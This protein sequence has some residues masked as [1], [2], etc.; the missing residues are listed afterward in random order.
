VVIG[1]IVAVVSVTYC[2]VSS[3]MRMESAVT[4]DAPAVKMESPLG[5]TGAGKEWGAGKGGPKQGAGDSY[6]GGA[7]ATPA[8]DEE[9][10]GAG[11]R[12]LVA[13]AGAADE[14]AP[15]TNRWEAP[16]F[17]G[18]MFLAGCYIA[19]MASNWGSPSATVA[20]N[21]MPELSTASMWARMGSQFMTEV[22]FFCKALAST[23]GAP[24]LIRPMFFLTPRPPSFSPCRVPRCAHSVQEPPLCRVVHRPICV[25]PTKKKRLHKFP[26]FTPRWP[27]T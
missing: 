4:V 17:H 22:L 13:P 23:R 15:A 27:A 24:L 7:A 21:G 18:T 16:I 25:K 12:Q 5:A 11:D 1:L 8:A 6:Q 20:D 14:T 2:A 9:A 3:A 10:G 26:F 19:M